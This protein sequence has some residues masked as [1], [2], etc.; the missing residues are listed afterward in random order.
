[1]DKLKE[2]VKASIHQ[3]KNSPYFDKHPVLPKETLN[4]TDYEFM[5]SLSAAVLQMRPNKLHWV[6]IS[7]LVT[8]SIF[9]IWANFAEVDE[10]SRGNGVVVPSGQNQILQNLEGGIISEILIKEG[11]YIEKDQ[12]LVRINNEKST[13]A[14]ASSALKA[15]FLRA[16]IQR[17]NAELARQPFNIENKDGLEEVNEFYQNELELYQTNLRQ[18]D[19]RIQI[20]KEQLK[21][22]QN[23]I[24]DAKQSIVHLKYSLEMITKEVE[25]TKPM[26]ERGIR[27]QVDFLKLQ[28]EENDAKQRLQSATM[29][30]P[31]L[32]SELSEINKKINEANEIFDSKT[33]ETLNETISHLKELEASSSAAQDQVSR[34]TIRA[35]QNGIVQKLH[36][37]T[38]GGAV[39]PAQDLVEIVPTDSKPLVE[40]KIKPS[41]IAFIYIGQKAMLKFSAYD[42][43]IYG[44]VEGQVV[45]I[46]PDTITE[47][48]DKTFYIVRI[49]TDQN[50]L[51]SSSKP[52]NIIPGMTASVDII[53]GKKSILDYILK[54]ILKTKQYTFTER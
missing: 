30:I 26:V 45:N 3:V 34:T 10:I 4:E 41:D 50:Y 49:E 29:S 11:D 22:K 48:D 44:G 21:Q 35:P 14:V 20:L 38:I 24:E 6:L 15:L 19:S 13:S 43:S 1:M 17:L 33:R 2:N 18:L 27:S 23:E 25:M 52:M 37:N 46:S 7:F 51:G 47:K 32:N 31:K 40:V 54:P 12:V 16:Q 42:F 9:L 5:N 28:R 39:K 53:T 36:I 8:I